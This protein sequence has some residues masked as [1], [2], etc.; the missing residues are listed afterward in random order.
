MATVIL[1][2][3]EALRSTVK[4]VEH[5]VLQEA[6][7]MTRFAGNF[8]STSKAIASN[9]QK[10][11]KQRSKLMEQY[12]DSSMVSKLMDLQKHFN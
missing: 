2:K 4:Q 3:R 8:G 12:S 5:D 9:L 7:R 1:S 10:T 11:V 6:K